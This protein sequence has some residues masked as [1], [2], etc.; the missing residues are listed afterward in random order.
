MLSFVLTWPSVRAL[1]SPRLSPACQ[2][3]PRRRTARV[4]AFSGQDAAKAKE[5][6]QS[7][8]QTGAR[9]FA[10]LKRAS[11]L[12]LAEALPALEACQAQDESLSTSSLLEG[13]WAFSIV[14]SPPSRAASSLALL[15][16]GI[17]PGVFG[18]SLLERTPSSL[19][20]LRS[21]SATIR[22][23]QPRLEV[24]SELALA[25][26]PNGLSLQIFARLEV[27]T[28]RRL[29]ET[30][31]DVLVNGT[32]IALPAPLQY[33]RV[34]LISYLDDTMCVLRDESGFPTILTRKGGA[35]PAAQSTTGASAVP[36]VVPVV[37]N[38]P[39]TIPVE[40]E[41]ESQ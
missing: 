32:S 28:G 18:L 16:P 8:L 14:G 34:L 12:E 26:M 38:G 3:F 29:L 4:S 1:K 41:E 15:L 6:V 36:E 30:W 20:S 2:A 5:R 27:Q 24:A 31:T 17:S 33:S 35:Q 22:P 25:G 7:T 11:R 39:V 37:V 23:T 9:S 10:S 19:M 40:D 13:E 21:L